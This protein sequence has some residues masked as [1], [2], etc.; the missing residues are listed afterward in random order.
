MKSVSKYLVAML[1]LI[2]S[3]G[4]ALPVAAQSVLE[5]VV[6]T[7]QKRGKLLSEYGHSIAQVIYK[8]GILKITG[9]AIDT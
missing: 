2:L 3:V 4:I 1:I 8:I 9:L 5:E 6:V 7:A